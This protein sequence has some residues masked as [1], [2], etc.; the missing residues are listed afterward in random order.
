MILNRLVYHDRVS[1]AREASM[2]TLLPVSKCRG[3]TT[4]AF[5]NI[6]PAMI[7]QGLLF[8]GFRS[9]LYLSF[10][11]GGANVYFPKGEAVGSNNV[12]SDPDRKSVV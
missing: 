12:Q 3:E 9:V 2:F 1:Y 6:H 8:K 4:G 11:L 10:R 7:R 5:I